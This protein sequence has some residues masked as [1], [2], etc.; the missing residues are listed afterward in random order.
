MHALH[1]LCLQAPAYLRVSQV[2][3]F[4]KVAKRSQL[5]DIFK[6]NYTKIRQIETSGLIEAN[7]LK[8]NEAVCCG[9]KF[10]PLYFFFCLAFLKPFLA[11]PAE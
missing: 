7:L 6:Q 3:V 9:I 1:A 10:F 4:A 2:R 11:A 8:K 5:W